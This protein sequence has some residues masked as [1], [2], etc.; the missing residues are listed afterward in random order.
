MMDKDPNR[1]PTFQEL[2]KKIPA[3]QCAYSN[4]NPMVE[5]ILKIRM[6]DNKSTEVKAEIEFEVGQAYERIYHWDTAIDHYQDAKNI[7]QL[8]KNENK[9]ARVSYSLSLLYFRIDLVEQGFKIAEPQFEL[10]SR[11][12]KET[13]HHFPF[14]LLNYAKGHLLRGEAVQSIMLS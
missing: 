14:F 5:E 4:E 11:K 1:R 7:L 8:W 12:Y 3:E 10:I 9:L 13:E 2:L 6:E